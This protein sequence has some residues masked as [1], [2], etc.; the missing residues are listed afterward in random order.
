MWKA[1]WDIWPVSRLIRDSN[2]ASGVKIGVG[3]IFCDL[4]ESRFSLE[5]RF[6]FNI[7]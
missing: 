7:E 6:E 5:S 4:L 3:F 1:E 2:F